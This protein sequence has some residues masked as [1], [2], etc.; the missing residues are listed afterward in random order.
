M[1]YH[2]CKPFLFLATIACTLAV[3]WPKMLTHGKS[4]PRKHFAPE[5]A[6]RTLLFPAARN[7]A[8]IS[9]NE[10][11]TNPQPIYVDAPGWFLNYS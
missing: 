3:L 6:W 1:L 2:A 8:P 10:L 9:C 11:L 4:G 7:L 5:K